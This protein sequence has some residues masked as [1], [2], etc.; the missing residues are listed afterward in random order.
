MYSDDGI[1]IPSS[2]AA[3]LAP[4]QSAKLHHEAGG[5]KDAKEK[6]REKGLETPY[7]VMLQSFNFLG[8]ED[9][10]GGSRS[11]QNQSSGRIQQCWEFEHPRKDAALCSRGVYPLESL[12][13]AADGLSMY[14]RIA[15][16]KHT[17]CSHG[18][19]NFQDSIRWDL[20]WL[21]GIF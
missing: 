4:I 12:C 11:Q 14:I 7:V 2:Y 1:S 15:D 20:A 5:S 13:V 9:S 8:E 3:F 6:D 18:I 10:G 21:R 16:H 17:Q 19:V